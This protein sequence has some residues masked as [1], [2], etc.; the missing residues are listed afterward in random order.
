MNPAF[1]TFITSF[2]LPATVAG[3]SALAM[4][5]FLLRNELYRQNNDEMSWI[6]QATRLIEDR[7]YEEVSPEQ[8]AYDAIRGMADRDRWSGFIDPEDTPQYREESEGQYE[9][10]GFVVYSEGEPLTVL[11]CFPG[12]P[13]DLA[14]LETG[15][16]IIG[17]DGEDCTGKN[18]NEIIRRIK[19]TGGAD[20]PV[21]IRVAPYTPPGEEPRP[22]RELEVTRV[23][24]FKQ[25]VFNQRIVDR[26]RG[27]AYVR[28]AAFHERSTQELNDALAALTTDGMKSLVLDMR[29][30]GGG[31]LD[32]ALGVISLFLDEG[33][34]LE[35]V[36]RTADST[37]LYHASEEDAPFKGL[38]LALLLDSRSASASE[39]VAGAL[40]DHQRA[41][42]V[43]N[44]T[45]GKGF[46]QSMISQ[47]FNVNGEQKDAIL[48]IT[49]SRYFTP[50]GRSIGRASRVRDPEHDGEPTGLWPD[51]LAPLE[52]REEML[53]LMRYLSD[54]EIIDETWAL[55][56]E[57]C[58]EH[59][60]F[61]AEEFGFAD[62][63][64]ATAVD[65]LAGKRLFNTLR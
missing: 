24:I 54:Q 3:V 44:R 49:T 16:R 32:Q 36:G 52:T 39:I 34:V 35:T 14:G 43:G 41:L 33:A 7:Y 62:R 9:G 1:R 18:N 12:G 15:D 29:G 30:N 55:I 20:T 6:R 31:F 47:H 10:I 37:R 27:I 19:A 17:V 50:A 61:D 13:A 40:Q 63:Q 2:V 59:T 26:D 64:L 8:L 57:R 21:K 11:Y 45:Y 28:L 42:L 4:F 22:S 53:L 23:K 46:V 65:V 51:L 48:K 25:S 38:P 5:Q 56:E 60:R 58:P